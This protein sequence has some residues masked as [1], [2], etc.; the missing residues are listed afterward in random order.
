MTGD[1]HA[2]TCNWQLGLVVDELE[3]E[4][5]TGLQ[6]DV[7]IH[8]R[9]DDA[10]FQV[11]DDIVR[12]PDLDQDLSRNELLEMEC[13]VGI[14][15][16]LAI[17]EIEFRSRD[18]LARVGI[19]HCSAQGPCAKKREL[20]RLLRDFGGRCEG[21]EARRARL[22]VEACRLPF[23]HGELEPSIRSRACFDEG[24]GTLPS[25]RIFEDRHARS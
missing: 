3:D 2:G 11:L 15:L 13:S 16:C 24:R 10:G 6:L 17:A 25:F 5:L 8:V 14:R 1:V 19:A 4:L 22:D 7:Q 18:S 12:V 21:P 23:L 9:I 20:Q